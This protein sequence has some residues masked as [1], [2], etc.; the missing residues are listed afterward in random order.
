MNA[1]LK[2]QAEAIEARQAKNRKRDEK[3]EKIMA[4][5]VKA[6]ED[7]LRKVPQYQGECPLC[8]KPMLSFGSKEYEWDLM[9][10]SKGYN[11]C[12][13]GGDDKR[14]HD[15]CFFSRFGHLD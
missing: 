3:E 9:D 6:L 12:L 8:A 11:D 15:S 2:E 7:G 13:I 14:Y 5:K 10:A 1:E 4:K